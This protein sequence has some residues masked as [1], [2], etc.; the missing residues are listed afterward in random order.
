MAALMNILITMISTLF[1]AG[2]IIPAKSVTEPDVVYYASAPIPNED[3]HGNDQTKSSPQ[4][5]VLWKRCKNS[6][7]PTC[8]KQID[9]AIINDDRTIL[10]VT[11]HCCQRLILSGKSC[12]DVFVKSIID[13][14]SCN[15]EGDSYEL[16]KRSQKL[17]NHCAS[18]AADGPV[19][20]PL[21]SQ[22]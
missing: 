18:E 2:A 13:V 7:T 20:S 6:V 15:E 3:D 5:F 16:W 22:E 17:W 10:K 14:T 9:E 4:F 21:P 8:K 1:I 12:L 19:S 11:N